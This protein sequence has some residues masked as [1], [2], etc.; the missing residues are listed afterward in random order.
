MVFD[1][2]N[3]N[4]EQNFDFR[5][6]FGFSSKIL[7]HNFDLDQYLDFSHFGQCFGLNF[8]I[9]FSFFQVFTISSHFSAIVKKRSLAT[10]PDLWKFRNF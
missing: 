9:V 3:F 6:I 4:F 5:A 7:D 2:E 8:I 1:F 10:I